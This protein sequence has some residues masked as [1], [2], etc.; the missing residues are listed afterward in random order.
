[1]E[2]K[3]IFVFKGIVFNKNNEILIDNRK[4]KRLEGADGK[5]ELPGGKIEFGETPEQTVQREVYEETG[6]N[7]QV[8]EIIPYSNVS[9]WEYKECIQHTIVFSYICE[10]KDTNHTDITDNGINE[11]RWINYTELENYDFL[12]GAKEAIE[13]AIKLRRSNLNEYWN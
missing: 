1:M 9:I 5:W 8:K 3:T 12:P 13:S 2:K 7:V 11:Y 6:Y 10:L 4:E